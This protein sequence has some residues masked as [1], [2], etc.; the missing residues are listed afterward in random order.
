MTGLASKKMGIKEGSRAYFVN[1]PE[2][3]IKVIDPSQLDLAKRLTGK[4]EYIHFF[5]Q[6]PERVQ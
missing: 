5:H 1:A 2:D 6:E 4:F 3:A